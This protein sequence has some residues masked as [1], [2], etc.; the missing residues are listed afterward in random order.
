MNGWRAKATP[1][2]GGTGAIS[3]LRGSAAVGGRRAPGRETPAARP[4][5]T[6]P[7]FTARAGRISLQVFN[8]PLMDAKPSVAI[9]SDHA[10]FAYKTALIEHLER[11]G[12]AVRDFGAK[13]AES[14]DYPVF[15]RPC[16]EAVARGEQR[17]G[18]VLGGSGNGEAIVANKVRGVRCALVFSEDT[19]RWGRGHNNANCMA[20]GERTITLEQ[21]LRFADLFLTTPFEGGRHQRRVD[22]IEPA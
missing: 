16:A 12:Y 1:N 13:S 4:P 21:A 8:L 18:I 6:S 7:R 3:T 20:I 9:A 10:G 2:L 14:S 17:F 5:E 22:Q 15:I 19:A 11:Q